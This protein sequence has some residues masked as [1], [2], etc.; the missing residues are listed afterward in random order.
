MP[1]STPQLISTGMSK[2]QNSS[3]KRHSFPGK[4]PINPTEFNPF[5]ALDLDPQTA[6]PEQL[7][8]AYRAAM[9]HRH[10]AAVL[11]HPNTASNLPQQ[12]QVQQAFDYLDAGQ[13][14]NARFQWS[15]L[16]RAVFHPTLPVGHPNVFTALTPGVITPS[17]TTLMPEIPDKSSVRNE[18]APGAV[19][20][21]WVL[22]GLGLGTVESIII[23]EWKLS[24]NKPPNAVSIS[25]VTGRF[26][27]QIMSHDL[28]GRPVPVPV[29]KRSTARFDDIFLRAPYQN[30]DEVTVRTMAINVHMRLPP[31]QR[32]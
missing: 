14:A 7:R 15:P 12:V 9:R 17:T 1:A 31:D 3:D 27:Y 6:T 32:P 24:R 10:E 16:H 5:A 2:R 23:G 18:A 20:L 8:L 25:F 29:S 11:R 22:F 21:D 13:I 28:R 19:H 26:S 4:A 30:M